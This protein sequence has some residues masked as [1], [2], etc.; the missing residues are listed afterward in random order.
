MGEKENII[1]CLE[2]LLNKLVRVDRD[3]LD[4]KTQKELNVI[5][6]EL[7]SHIAEFKNV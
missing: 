4:E 5:I 6:D 1:F 2:G 3:T 7:A